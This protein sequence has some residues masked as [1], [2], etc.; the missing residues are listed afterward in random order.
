L[1]FYHDPQ[2][3]ATA[4]LLLSRLYQSD[5]EWPHWLRV[6]R[7]RRSR[8]SNTIIVTKSPLTA[9][10][11][12]FALAGEFA[13]PAVADFRPSP[14]SGPVLVANNLALKE[15]SGGA[16]TLVER[17]GY[18]SAGDGGLMLYTYS[19]HACGLNS[20][21]G[22]DGSQ[23]RA[24]DGK[25]WIWQPLGLR[26][27]PQVFGCKGDGITDDT[28][29]LQRAT[30][31]QAGGV[32]FIIHKLYKL[33]GSL[34]ITRPIQLVG[35]ERGSGHGIVDPTA[36]GCTAG[37]RIGRANIMLLAITADGTKV[38]GVCIDSPGVG[39]TSGIAIYVNANNVAVTNNQ[40]NGACNSI[41][42]TASGGVN[43]NTGSYI[44]NNSIVPANHTGC[45][46]IRVGDRSTGGATTDIHIAHNE[47]FCNAASATGML[48]KDAGGVYVQGND[49]VHCNY[50]TAIITGA[51]Q[52]ADGMLFSGTVIGDS[53][54]SGDLLIDTTSSSAII[55]QIA[56]TGSWMASATGPS[57]TIQNTGGGYIGGIHFAADL[58]YPHV[59]QNGV[60]IA[61][62]S[63]IT[64]DNSTICSPA[65]SSKT[66]IQITTAG[67]TAIRNSTIG[68]CD[69]TPGGYTVAAGISYMPRSTGVVQILGNSILGTSTP[70]IY[71]PSALST[72]T[73]ANNIGVDNITGTTIAS[74]A[75]ITAPV[76]PI[77]SISGTAVITTV[78]G[79]WTGRE[80]T[81][82][83]ADT[84]SFATGG[85]IANALTATASVP[86]F[87]NFDGTYWHVK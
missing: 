52:Y 42:I 53:S 12:G 24:G 23:V 37:L 22:D 76:N 36:A 78:N 41:D 68:A 86:I 48:L 62:G 11:L 25:C 83:P 27:T 33:T 71:D 77:F 29:C 4:I 55:G 9:L 2:I 10:L 14:L 72:A 46:A 87:A 49:I 60:N 65:A 30:N 7:G 40:I 5:G 51:N 13:I 54:A 69:R 84:F 26:V 80:M 63:D 67:S 15:L 75:N 8:P 20:G 44:M 6:F 85:N 50:G 31:A 57:V 70:I 19:G 17:L 82:N 61:A 43:D 81:I 35:A 58:I 1:Q 74:G 73:I 39:N 45:N 59:N 56:I 64:I 18:A 3:R 34:T 32:L 28:S 38:D 79:G 21:D 66:M 16:N 47:I